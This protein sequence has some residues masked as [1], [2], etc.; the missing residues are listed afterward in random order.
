VGGELRETNPCFFV[1]FDSLSCFLAYYI[2]FRFDLLGCA[3][4][5]CRAH[6]LACDHLQRPHIK[7]GSCKKSRGAW[8]CFYRCSVLHR[9]DWWGEPVL[10][11][12]PVKSSAWP[13]W[14]V[15]ATGLTGGALST[16]VFGEKSL[17]WSSRLFTPSRRHQRIFTPERL[18]RTKHTSNILPQR[19]HKQVW[20][21]F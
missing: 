19:A 10:P 20:V 2:C 21:Q 15:T 9:S 4:C 6:Y 13:V 7:F 18:G 12:Y 16:Q 11:V 3:T 1:W 17:I 8:S 14:S 5:L